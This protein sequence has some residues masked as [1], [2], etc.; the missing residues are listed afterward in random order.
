MYKKKNMMS[1]RK[2]FLSISSTES[3]EH[4][5]QLNGVR[6]NVDKRVNTLIAS[7]GFRFCKIQN[8]N[9]KTTLRYRCH[10]VNLTP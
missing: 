10:R 3:Y 7:L 2:S 6:S 1:I 8:F 5:A 9:Y 4:N